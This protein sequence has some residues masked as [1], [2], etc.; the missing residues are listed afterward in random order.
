[1]SGPPGSQIFLQV[2]DDGGDD[3]NE[4]F[5]LC[6]TDRCGADDCNFATPMQE[7]TWYCFDT[8]GASGE[9]FPADPGY[10]ECGDGSDPGHSVYFYYETRCPT[11]TITIQA[12]IGGLCILDEPTD[13][14]SFALYIDDTPCDWAPQ[15]LLDCE[16]TDACDG[17]TYFFT[18]TYSAPVGTQL[19]MQLDG[20]DFTGDNSGQIRVD[21]GCPLDINYQSFTG[22]RANEVHELD[23]TVMEDEVL[24]GRFI[25][26]RSLNGE[27]F[28]SIGTVAG[29]DH[30]NNVG[31]GYAYHLTDAAP[32]PGHNFYRL[33]FTDVNGVERL[34]DVIDIY[35]DGDA[36]MEIVGLYPN[37]ARDLV[38]LDTYVPQAGSYV[39]RFVDMYG[40]IVLTQSLE[41]ETGANH[42]SFELQDLSA[43]VYMV[44]LSNKAGTKAVHKRLVRQ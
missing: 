29:H 11:F 34:S 15:V 8:D 27:D 18:R 33:R 32:V 38:N 4:P 12:N 40:K 14:L 30:V 20:F 28:G 41:L 16:L 23:W 17:T 9:S 31:Q 42:H 10:E 25:V 37:P 19:M 3:N 13:G 44:H 5:G 35:F 22:Y 6:V 2:F 43:G 1:V 26:E 7:A 39:V 21:E 24:S 36:G